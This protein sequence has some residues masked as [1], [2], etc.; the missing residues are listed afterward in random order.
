M[1]NPI[2]LLFWLI[3]DLTLDY[4]ENKIRNNQELI[5]WNK[6]LKKIFIF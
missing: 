2:N 1:N 4:L 3:N 5:E 6:L